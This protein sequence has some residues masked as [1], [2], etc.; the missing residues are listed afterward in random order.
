M[1]SSG[2]PILQ[3]LEISENLT[4]NLLIRD[5]LTQARTGVQSGGKLADSLGKSAA[6]P[7]D[8]LQMIATGESSGMLDK[9][10]YKV[11][12]F[13]DQLIQRTLKKVTAMIEPIFILFMGGIIAFIML[14]ILLPIFDMIK[15]FNPS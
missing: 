8:A 9:M 13:Y 12:N 4:H 1:L 11:A 3:A 7:L 15:I 5:V 10:L 6:F 2:V 14:S